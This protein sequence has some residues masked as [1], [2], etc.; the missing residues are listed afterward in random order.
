[1]KKNGYFVGSQMPEVEK[2]GQTVEST[3]S[4]ETSS[5]NNNDCEQNSPQ[6]KGGFG[7][8]KVHGIP[9]PKKT[10]FEIDISKIP[11]GSHAC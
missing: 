4:F 8:C 1:M 9:D 5:P 3:N 6:P 2:N 11:P 7:Y 10:K